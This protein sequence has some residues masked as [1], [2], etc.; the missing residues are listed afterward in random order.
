M[1]NRFN[2]ATFEYGGILKKSDVDPTV[3]KNCEKQR[4]LF[5]WLKNIGKSVAPPY[6]PLGNLHIDYI[7]NDSINAIAI[8]DNS[9]E[10]I[11]IF[12]GVVEKMY[13]INGAFLSNSC[14]FP[15]FGKAEKE[16]ASKTEF[17]SSFKNLDFIKM[18]KSNPLCEI[19]KSLSEWL[20]LIS[21]LFLLGHE[22][23]HVIKSHFIFL[24]EGKSKKYEFL[25][26][27]EG[28][29]ESIYNQ[30]LIEVSADENGVKSSLNTWLLTYPSIQV[31]Q[32]TNPY[33]IWAVSLGLLFLTFELKHY[34]T[35]RNP[36]Q[37]PPA[38]VR[39]RVSLLYGLAYINEKNK[40]Q[41]SAFL[42]GCNL[43]SKELIPLWLELEKDKKY[44]KFFSFTSKE[45]GDQAA[46]LVSQS[47]YFDNRII[48]ASAGKRAEILR[49]K[50]D[51]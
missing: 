4:E 44:K 19:R 6:F 28:I 51:N 18:G 7:N 43:A 35:S 42:K 31:L 12:Y 27:E 21:I 29:S 30:I 9:Y 22:I 39:F 48:T 24:H 10:F 32:E 1:R 33:Y 47:S 17:I 25:E 36:I 15:S 40:D 45:I 38:R 41:S 50:F 34:Q 23:G 37:Y 2:N 20:S 26:Y 46:K 16:V 13:I 49:E 8:I 11:G 5:S 3:W 14:V